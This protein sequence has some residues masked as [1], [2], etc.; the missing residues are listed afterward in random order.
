MKE[1]RNKGKGKGRRKKGEN[2][3]AKQNNCT[4]FEQVLLFRCMKRLVYKEM[5]PLKRSFCS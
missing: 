2:S 3:K 4:L 5:L 1:G